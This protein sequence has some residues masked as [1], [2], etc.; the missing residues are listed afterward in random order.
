MRLHPAAAATYQQVKFTLTH[1]AVDLV[2]GAG[3]D[4]GV[5]PR[6]H[7]RRLHGDSDVKKWLIGEYPQRGIKAVGISCFRQ[8]LSPA[9]RPAYSQGR[10]AWMAC[11]P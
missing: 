5:N 3:D 6:L 10:A 1:R 8:Q 9:P 7:Q 11:P 2:T 4:F